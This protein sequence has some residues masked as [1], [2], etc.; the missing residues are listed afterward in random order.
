V[1]VYFWQRNWCSPLFHLLAKDWLCC[2]VVVGIIE[3][4]RQHYCSKDFLDRYWAYEDWSLRSMME[5]SKY[6]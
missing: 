6:W 1:S 2:N 5:K 4:T 3:K